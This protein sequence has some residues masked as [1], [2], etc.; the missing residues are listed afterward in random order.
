MFEAKQI[1][2]PQKQ[3]MVYMTGEDAKEKSYSK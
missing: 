1:A 2:L 3:R